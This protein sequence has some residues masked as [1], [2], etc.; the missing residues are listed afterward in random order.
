MN[1]KERRKKYLINALMALVY[2]IIFFL[3]GFYFI[4]LE[5]EKIADYREELI[6]NRQVVKAYVYLKNAKKRR[7]EYR[8]KIDGIEYDGVSRY[9]PS[10]QHP[11]VGDSIWVY[12]KEDDPNVNLWVGMFEY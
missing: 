6:E 9:I 12:Y 11:E 10:R 7:F 4:H 2:I 8:F 5:R 1:S 3:C